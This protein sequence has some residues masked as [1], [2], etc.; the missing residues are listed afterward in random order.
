MSHACLSSGL[1]EHRPRCWVQQPVLQ[2]P[3]TLGSRE[4]RLS[5][6]AAHHLGL[7]A[8]Q[9]G[10]SHEAASST[11]PAAAIPSTAANT[12]AWVDEPDARKGSS[13]SGREKSPPDAPGKE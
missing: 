2:Q 12:L 1:L 6:V 7:P 13:E 3:F 10:Q 8:E 5:P 9:P 4:Q 11:S